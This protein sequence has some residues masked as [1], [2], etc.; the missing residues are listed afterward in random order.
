[1]NQG[2]DSKI[3]DKTENTYDIFATTVFGTFEM[4]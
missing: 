1:M 4:A 3:P 2:N